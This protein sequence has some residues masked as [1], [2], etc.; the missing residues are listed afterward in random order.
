[1]KKILLLSAFVFL[2]SFG[3]S[4]NIKI[5]RVKRISINHKVNFVSFAGSRNE[6]FINGK[7]NKGLSIYNIKKKYEEVITDDSGAGLNPQILPDGTIK[8]KKVTFIDGRK[9]TEY[10]V[11]SLNKKISNTQNKKTTIINLAKAKSSAK[12]IVYIDSRGNQKE[13]QPAG[14]VYYIWVSLSPDNSKILFTAS[15]KGTFVSDTTGKILYKLGKLNASSWV[16]NEWVIGMDD[17]DDGEVL[18]SS[19][20]DAIHISTAKRVKLV[21]KEN[22]IAVYPQVSPTLDRILFT[23]AKGEAYYANIRIKK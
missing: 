9:H 6:L 5:K 17:K 2:S 4:Q 1:M 18:L 11:S 15:G 19:T 23:N 10:I 14:N 3:F 13:L 16:N 7:E 21:N 12:K 20:I 8:Y 22:K